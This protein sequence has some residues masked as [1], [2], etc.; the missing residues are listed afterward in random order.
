MT[1]VNVVYLF[2][3]ERDTTSLSTMASPFGHTPRP[4]RV[5][6]IGGCYAGLAAATNLLDL[7]EG[8]APR[9]APTSE[10]LKR[11]VPIDITIVD[12]RD[13]FYHVIGSPLALASSDYAAKAWV[14]FS[15]VPGL[16]HPSFS[17]IHGS[18][19]KVDINT[20]TA[21]IRR[22]DSS[23]P[24]D[25]EYD[26]LI[27]ASGLRRA[28]PV[29]PQS[30]SRNTYLPE[31]QT[32]IDSV[33]NARNG[34]V[35]IGGGAVGIEMAAE[36]KLVNPALE[37]TLI[38]SR[39]RL[40]S[41][42]PLPDDFKDETLS[43]LRSTGVQVV[44]GQRVK[45]ISEPDSETVISLT[46]SNG[47]I[48]RTSHVINAIS[49]SVPTTTYLPPSTVDS[50]GFV[51]V[52]PSLHFLNGDDYHLAAGDIALWSGIKRC[53]AAMHMGGFCAYNIHQH[54]ISQLPPTRPSSPYARR[55]SD[56]FND[57]P[58]P[59]YEPVYKELAEHPAVIG[60]AIGSTGTSYSPTEGTKS[61]PEV[62]KYMFGDDL[63]F[64][65]CY[66]YMKLGEAPWSMVEKVATAP[67]DV[68]T[69]D[70]GAKIEEEE[71][72]TPTLSATSTESPV[73]EPQTP[74][75]AVGNAEITN[76]EVLGDEGAGTRKVDI[77]SI[78]TEIAQ[79]SIA[80]RRHKNI[81]SGDLDIQPVQVATA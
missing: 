48:V 42:E 4:Q 73:V 62:L 1:C 68:P 58:S 17:F 27:A 6:I 34:V 45:D 47:D 63:G 29:V 50:E 39:D 32:H 43:V 72:S 35:V 65:N 33:M 61:G 28:W 75:D 36:L 5:L 57:I 15:D 77:D 20:K 18:V 21:V 22:K 38:H 76:F 19:E 71:Q 80:N 31:A 10:I 8:R 37:V 66:N 81:D 70:E 9:F 78:V 2:G 46:L 41:S 67:T 40:L 26:Y 74:V 30:L 7:C 24:V 12:E 16:Q 11:D 53:G 60:L 56:S 55:S 69:M 23:S 79:A 52:K 59:A 25:Q 54:I 49:R 51:K 14:K 44:T 3:I 13:G 64:S